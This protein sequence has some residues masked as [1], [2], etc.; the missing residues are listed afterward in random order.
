MWASKAFRLDAP[1][2]GGG[3]LRDHLLAAKRAG[4]KVPE[5]DVGLPPPGLHFVLPAFRH[6]SNRR[7]FTPDGVPLLIRDQAVL[8]WSTL[9]GTAL[10]PWEF[11]LL[12]IL[13]HAWID[14]IR[15]EQPT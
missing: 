9:N 12:M 8:A 2:K 4:A 11:H 6:L 1:Q 15:T 13:D 5:L 10:R 3:T 14:A 7:D